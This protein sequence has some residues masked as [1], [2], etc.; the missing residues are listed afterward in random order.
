G[1]AELLSCLQIRCAGAAADVSGTGC[2]QSTIDSLRS[3]ETKLDHRIVFGSQADARRLSRDKALEVENIEERR[4]EELTF[5]DRTNNPNQRFVRKNQ[6]SFRNCIYVAGQL[7]PAQVI[8]KTRIEQRFTIIAAL[9]GKVIDFGVGEV[10]RAKEIDRC[11]Q[12]GSHG[13]LPGKGILPKRDVKHRVMV[14]HSGFEITAR[15]SD[16]VKVGGQGGEIVRWR[17]RH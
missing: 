10:K 6:S 9:R 11:R 4:F 14:G 5:N 8:E 12:A 2:C 7:Q 15:H 17:L 1:D 16:L 3:A 13:E